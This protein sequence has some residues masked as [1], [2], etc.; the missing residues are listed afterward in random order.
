MKML[1]DWILMFMLNLFDLKEELFGMLSMKMRMLNL[2]D[3]K[4]ELFG[5]R[6]MKMQTKKLRC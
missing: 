5:M 4:Q 1:S 3:L 6:S 2:V